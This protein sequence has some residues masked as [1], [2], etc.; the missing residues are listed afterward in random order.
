MVEIFKTD[1]DS[2]QKAIEIIKKLQ[3]KFPSYKI[4]FDLEDCDN[5]LRIEA[6]SIKIKEVIDILNEMNFFCEIIE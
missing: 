6:K 5:I 1:V 2:K 3:E 4:N